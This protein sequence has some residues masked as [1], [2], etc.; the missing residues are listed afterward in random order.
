MVPLSFT[1]EHLETLHELDIEAKEMVRQ[2]GI[3]NFQRI[4]TVACHPLFIASLARLTLE[5]AGDWAGE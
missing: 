3:P 2:A 1:C 4:P 5:A